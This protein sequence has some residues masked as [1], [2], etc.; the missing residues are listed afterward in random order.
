M[1]KGTYNNASHPAAWP[2]SRFSTVGKKKE[3]LTS[4]VSRGTLHLS[5]KIWWRTIPDKT[6]LREI[7]SNSATIQ[8]KKK[9]NTNIIKYWRR[10]QETWLLCHLLPGDHHHL[11]ASSQ[12][13]LSTPS[14][15]SFFKS[16]NNA[17]QKRATTSAGAFWP[18]NHKYTYLQAPCF[19]FIIDE[20]YP[21]SAV[22]QEF[23][24]H[25][26]FL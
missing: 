7:M 17:Q 9:S 24:L 23:S 13:L 18:P 2:R 4:A 16:L 21:S 19:A 1:Q 14:R 5:S 20:G 26:T 15:P 8:K 25:L 12:V 22:S 3:S 11:A 6:V 10:M